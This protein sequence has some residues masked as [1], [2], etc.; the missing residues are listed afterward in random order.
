MPKS[1]IMKILS[2]HLIVTAF[3][4]ACSNLIA[5]NPPHSKFDSLEK[6]IIQ[7]QDWYELPGLAIG[8]ILDGE[9]KYT[10]G[11]GVMCYDSKEP[12]TENTIFSTAS[13][14]KLFVGTAIMQLYEEKK[15]DLDESITK[16]VPYFK[17]RD[18][19]FNKITIRQ[20]LS[21]TSGLPDDEGEEFYSSWKNPEFDDDALKRYV[22]G[23]KTKSLISIPGTEYIYSNIGYEILGCVISEVSGISVE[24][25]IKKN[26]L[27]QIGMQ[28]SNML[29]KNVDSSLLA[30]PHILNENIDFEINEYFPYTRR[31]AA[32]GTL[33]SNINEMCRFA[34]AILNNG[35]IDG[36]RIL[37]ESSI[38]L[39]LTQQNGN[40]A[41]LSWHVQQVDSVTTL[42]FHA[43][44]DPGFRTEI[45]LIPEKAMGVVV[46][47][48]SW[49]HQIEPLAY[50]A[51]NYMLEDD[52]Q[53]WFTFYHGSTWKIM[54]NNNT[55]NAVDK[56]KEIVSKNGFENFHPA[57]LNQHSNLLQD[58][59]KTLD[60]IEFKKLNIE[61]Y[62]KTFQLYNSL[63]E[64]YVYLGDTKNAIVNYEKSIE[65]KCD[66][67]AAI[68]KLK[69]IIANNQVQINPL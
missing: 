25:F 64:L 33:L 56:I 27:G 12:V 4:F 20:L 51:L 58:L 52:V 39:M 50:K 24:E 49:E 35:I 1:S 61:F 38:K 15:I 28:K 46:M 5:E 21:H 34:V 47:T 17:L 57:I 29:L 43:G 60:A 62:P 7:Y 41:G 30:C 8:L 2:I 11:F 69:A 14:S 10:K 9:V 55:E 54:R 23:L 36:S 53:D 65:L 6:Y 19:L 22:K 16:Y 37:Q 68:D 59:G 18:S 3:I 13:I 48:N 44:G 31:H 67:N 40:P 63:A 32:S 26:I 42:I 45:I 66:N